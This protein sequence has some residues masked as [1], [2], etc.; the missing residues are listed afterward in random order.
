MKPF[1]TS[2]SFRLSTCSMYFFSFSC[3][4]RQ[5]NTIIVTREKR[6]LFSF[7]IFFF[8]LFFFPS[9]QVKKVTLTLWIQVKQAIIG[10]A[11]WLCVYFSILSRMTKQLN[12][13]GKTE[14]DSEIL[15]RQHMRKKKTQ[16]KRQRGDEW[17]I[18]TVVHSAPIC[19]FDYSYAEKGKKAVNEKHTQ[20]EGTCIPPL[21]GFA[22]QT[23]NYLW[24]SEPQSKS[25]HSD[26]RLHRLSCPGVSHARTC[27]RT[28]ARVAQPLT[29]N[30]AIE[31]CENSDSNLYIY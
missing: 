21:K 11:T 6:R 9:L 2:R 1:S 26:T 10:V 18:H 3:R 25:T 13:P 29:D 17:K 30:P 14:V 22:L 8:K 24:I 5:T 19:G 20:K 23:C 15:N 16:H 27:K 12:S 4:G 31:C 7:Y 28:H